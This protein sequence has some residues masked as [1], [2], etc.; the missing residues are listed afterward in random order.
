MI[1]LKGARFGTI[2]GLGD[3]IV[4]EISS[5]K[6]KQEPIIAL[7]TFSGTRY[8]ACLNA[9]GVKDVW[10][11]LDNDR[12]TWQGTGFIS[13]VG[14]IVIPGG[15]RVYNEFVLEITPNTRWDYI[16]SSNVMNVIPDD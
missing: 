10:T 14:A 1:I 12:N 9:L 8:G 5:P 16:V 3:V 6:K 7:V 4:G 15:N 13:K 2:T 11:F